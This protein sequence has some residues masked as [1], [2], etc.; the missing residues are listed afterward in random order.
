MLIFY[1]LKVRG[2]DFMEHILLLFFSFLIEAI[3]MWQYS[4]SL[5]L[6][7]HS[8]KVKGSFIC[9]LYSILFLFSFMEKVWLN[10]I[11]YFLINFLFLYIQFKIDLLIAIFHSAILTTIMGLSELF[12][13]SF[14]SQFAPHF[15]ENT[16]SG[17]IIYT[18]SS[19]ILFL[20]IIY[21]LMHFFKKTDPK[22]ENYIDYT[23]FILMLIPVSCLFIII[24]FFNIGEHFVF[25][26]PINIM[27]TLSTVL[28]LF[29]NLLVFGMNQYN[30]R[31]NIEF[32]DMQL[33]LQKEADSAEY[34]K[35]LLS[36]TENRN[37]LIHD[38]KKHLQTIK[39]LNEKKDTSKINAYIC[40]LLDSSD[41]QEP[42]RICDN[43]ILNAILGRY[44]RQCSIKSISFHADIRSN[45]LKQFSP[46]DLTSLFCNLMDNA[47]EAVEKIPESFIEVTAQKKENSPFIV[48]V[49]INSCRTA[50]A[51]D[52][53]HLPISNKENTTKHGYGIKSI[54]KVTKKHGGNLQMYYDDS[55]STFHTIITLKS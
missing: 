24:T 43:E 8:A 17:L 10:I 33:L 40:Q 42:A 15:L 45:I 9:F 21:L 1:I 54:K 13:F 31:R 5:F 35:M 38:I 27:V 11:V 20:T 7:A 36:Q 50:P 4:S 55:S 39:L 52:S 14:M 22:Q 53:D 34:Y 6:S 23:D 46:Y 25:I 51:Y 29:I 28:L 18:L 37:I 47:F 12:M 41:L 19:K 30:H 3:I 44:Q 16:K 26:A 48:I 2:E 32:T 49:V